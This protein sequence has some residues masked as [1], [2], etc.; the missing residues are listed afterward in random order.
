[1]FLNFV[2]AIFTNIFFI[3][4]DKDINN[5]KINI[6]KKNSNKSLNK[7]NNYRLKIFVF[8]I[9]CTKRKFVLI[10]HALQKSS[11][12]IFVNNKVENLETIKKNINLK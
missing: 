9:K 2:Y 5:A 8:I 12:S 6:I 11:A 7:T 1:L 4:F 10:E 3:A